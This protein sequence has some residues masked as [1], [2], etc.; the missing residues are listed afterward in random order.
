M[1]VSASDILTLHNGQVFE[2]KLL[3]IGACDIDFKFNGESFTIPADD[4]ALVEL[5]RMSKRRERRLARVITEEGNCWKGTQDGSNHGHGGG[6]FALGFLFGP[7]GVIGCA[8]SNRTP[9]KSANM[10]SNQNNNLW[11]NGEYLDCYKKSANGK[12]VGTSAIGFAVWLVFL[13]AI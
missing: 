1:A 12:A 11:N 3:H 10:I 13:L 5:E 8:L 9:H 7:F 2:G 4:I 6:H